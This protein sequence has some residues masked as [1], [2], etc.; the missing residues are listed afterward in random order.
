MDIIRRA[1]EVGSA[2]KE[3]KPKSSSSRIQALD[4]IVRSSSP[5]VPD[6]AEME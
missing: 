1:G 3:K 4:I 5:G 6:D 2:R